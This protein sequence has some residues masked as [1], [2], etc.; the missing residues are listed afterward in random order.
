MKQIIEIENAG[1][2]KEAFEASGIMG[3]IMHS[4]RKSMKADREM[5][6]FGDT[7]WEKEIPE[8]V[9]Q[10]KQ[11]GIEEFTV[12]STYSGLLETAVKKIKDSYETRE[13]EK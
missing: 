6:N 9:K 7:I 8:I 1:L 11:Y 12:S 4:Y 5:L 10:L 13:T 2:T 3:I